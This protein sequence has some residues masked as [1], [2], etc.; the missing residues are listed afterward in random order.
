MMGGAL[1][2]RPDLLASFVVFFAGGLWGL[3]WYPMRAIQAAGISSPW[4]I[5]LVSGLATL[6]LAPFALWRWRQ[7]RANARPVL[8]IGLLVGT[9]FVA[10][11]T[12][13]L[14]TEVARALLLFYLTPVWGS[15]FGR[16]FL[17]ERITLPRLVAI[18]FGLAGLYVVLGASGPLPIPARLGD[19]LALAAGLIW[20][21][22]TVA[23]RKYPGIPSVDL[24]ASIF[25]CN[26]VISMLMP[27]LF[28]PASF[29]AEVPTAA[30][31]DLAWLWILGT[32][33]ILWPITQQF[34]FWGVPRVEAARSGLLLLSEALLGV[35]SAAI[36][37][38]EPFGWR[39]SIGSAL[40][41]GAA[42]LDTLGTIV[43]RT[44]QPSRP[45]AG[46]AS[47]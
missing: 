13:L 31:L 5:V 9:G 14:T 41:L 10:Y 17:G 25:T 26:F 27:L 36:I 32:G 16:I 4:V 22:A 1:K 40:I 6:V 47:A 24:N 18:A 28:I 20:T 43:A 11:N 33:V 39:E 45:S 30:Q 15:L 38:D 35:T 2:S 29:L 8:L 3:Y 34:L 19:W 46:P 42:L 21:L 37:T 7:L 12:S 44:P 23:M